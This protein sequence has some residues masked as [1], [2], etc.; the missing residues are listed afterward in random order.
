MLIERLGSQETRIATPIQYV[1]YTLVD[2]DISFSQTQQIV[3]TI[4]SFDLANHPERVVLRMKP[5]YVVQDIAYDPNNVGQTVEE[6]ISPIKKWLSPADYSGVTAGTF[7]ETLVKLLEQKKNDTEF[8]SWAFEHPL[9]LQLED[10]LVREQVHYD[11]FVNM[12]SG[13]TDPV[14]R[15]EFIADYIL[16]MRYTEQA[17]FAKKGEALLEKE[18]AL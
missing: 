8:I 12:L 18:Q 6:L 2:S 3:E 14:V 16:E 17:D 13:I 7:Q 11:L 4:T 5:E 9:W 1:L 15:K 10:P